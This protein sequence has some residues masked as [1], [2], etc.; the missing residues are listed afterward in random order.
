MTANMIS[1]A[2]YSDCI[3][4]SS[5]L[6][7][8]SGQILDTALTTPVTITRNNDSFAL[9]KRDLMTSM[10]N[11]IHF[12]DSFIELMSVIRRVDLGQT[13]ETSN[14][15][16]WVEEFDSEERSELVNEVYSALELAKSTN[17]WDEVRN[18]IHEWRESALAL[19]S[20]ELGE[21]FGK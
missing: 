10:A 16:K 4:T 12:L 7:R 6:N 1:N 14:G 9:V 11:E 20:E 5:E 21:A 19:T 13:I 8:R 2:I 3:V 17:D 15:F 18:V